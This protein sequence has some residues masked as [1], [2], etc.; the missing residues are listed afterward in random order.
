MF[1]FN[2]SNY[3][4]KKISFDDNMYAVNSSLT[5]AN[6]ISSFNK[7]NTQG[8]AWNLQQLAVAS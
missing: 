4:N 5:F 7:E 2:L 6:T 8:L 1:S 3:L